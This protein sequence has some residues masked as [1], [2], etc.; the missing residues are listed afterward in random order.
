[1]FFIKTCSLC[2]AS[3]LFFS[4]LV[5]IDLQPCYMQRTDPKNHKCCCFHCENGVS[6]SYGFSRGWEIE[7]ECYYIQ[8]AA[9]NRVYSFITGEEGSHS[10]VSKHKPHLFVKLHQTK[11]YKQR[12][13]FVVDFLKRPSLGP[14]QLYIAVHRKIN[15]SYVGLCSAKSQ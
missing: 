8:A 15:R 1:M 14:T 4:Q 11:P 7:R 3:D 2:R 6:P 9:P 12:A 10:S 5:R 13:Q